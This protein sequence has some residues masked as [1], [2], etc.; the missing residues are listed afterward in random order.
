MIRNNRHFCVKSG[1]IGAAKVIVDAGANI[2]VSNE[3]G[4]DV[5]ELMVSLLKQNPSDTRP[6]QLSAIM[7]REV[8]DGCMYGT[9]IYCLE[10]IL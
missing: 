3:D 6:K 9:H 4:E 5:L 10:N 1:N 2:H 8:P 7:P